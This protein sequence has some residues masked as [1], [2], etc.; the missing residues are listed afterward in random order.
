MAYKFKSEKN[1][2]SLLKEYESVTQKV[3]FGNTVLA[4]L[5][6]RGI[7]DV[8]LQNGDCSREARCVLWFFETKCVIEK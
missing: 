6:Y 2:T 4:A 1:K 8:I 3:L 5:I 7:Y